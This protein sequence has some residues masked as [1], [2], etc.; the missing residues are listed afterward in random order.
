MEKIVKELKQILSFKDSTDV[1]DIVLIAT[2]DPQMLI[3]GLITSIERDDS[4]K[5]EWWVIGVSLLSLPPQKMHWTLRTSQMTGMEIFTMG[6]EERFMKAI[7]FNKSENNNRV[8]KERNE[9]KEKKGFIK[10]IK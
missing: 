1:G 3:Y 9:K 8:S 4:R 2:K 6:G 7:D 10:R 5:E